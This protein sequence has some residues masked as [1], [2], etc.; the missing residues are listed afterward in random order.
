LGG[1]SLGHDGEKKAVEE[2]RVMQEDLLWAVAEEATA[3]VEKAV[4]EKPK[5]EEG[6]ARGHLHIVVVE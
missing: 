4:A 6:V 5:A 1:P 2:E 3:V